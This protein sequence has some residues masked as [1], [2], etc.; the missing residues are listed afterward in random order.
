MGRLALRYQVM[1]G[2]GG[3]TSESKLLSWDVIFILYYYSWVFLHITLAAQFL[4]SCVTFPSCFLHYP[5]PQISRFV[6]CVCI[7]QFSREGELMA[8]YRVCDTMHSFVPFQ[9]V[10]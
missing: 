6:L 10:S 1:A 5:F 4:W 7:K 8:Y 2:K 9:S 3:E